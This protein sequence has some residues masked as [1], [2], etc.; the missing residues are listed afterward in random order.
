MKQQII[1]AIVIT[2]AIAGVSGFIGGAL[3]TRPVREKAKQQIEFI[4]K[5]TDEQIL[6]FKND[7][8][9]EKAAWE[10]QQ[11]QN[12]VEQSQSQSQ[13][14]EQTQNQSL[15]DKLIPDEA[16]R[17]MM[18][19]GWLYSVDVENHQA[20]IDPYFWLQCE[21][22]T[23]RNTVI[24]FSRYFREKGESGWVEILSSRNDKK[25]ATYDSWE[26]IKILE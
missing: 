6:T 10:K 24:F 3:L 16:I 5:T 25:L 18:S 15:P 26:G 1:L 22:N 11:K 21:L 17:K 23:K 13:N 2:T 9:A 19:M 4:P 14:K 20:R 7:A 8:D 12:S